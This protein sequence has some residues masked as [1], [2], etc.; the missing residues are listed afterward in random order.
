MHTS[1]PLVYNAGWLHRYES[2]VGQDARLKLEEMNAFEDLLYRHTASRPTLKSL[3]DIGTCTGRYLRWAAQN[4]F[5]TIVG[6]DSSADAILYCSQVLT[7][8]L[9]LHCLDILSISEHKLRSLFGRQFDLIT[10]MFGTINHFDD[11]EQFEI[12]RRMRYM[13]NDKGFLVI[14]LWIQ[15]KCDF[16]LYEKLAAQLL[17]IRDI[18]VNKMRDI[19]RFAGLELIDWSETNSH[20]LFL[21]TR[22]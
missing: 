20:R 10:I 3:V 19:T 4:G 13:L 1:F 5:E 15:G 14:S 8:E 21:M 16:S 22:R 17:S 12:L 18:P 2:A 6:V 9:E 7:F 11:T